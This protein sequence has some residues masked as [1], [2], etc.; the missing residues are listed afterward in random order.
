M[1]P[2]KGPPLSLFDMHLA[3]KRVRELDV[4]R[5]F[6]LFWWFFCLLEWGPSFLFL[7]PFFWGGALIYL[8]L[9]GFHHHFLGLICHLEAS[10]K[11]VP[12]GTNM[13]AGSPWPS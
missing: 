8:G 12:Q 6:A 7:V 10:L 5:W 3:K 11:K 1:H 4:P 13:G 9:A 2:F